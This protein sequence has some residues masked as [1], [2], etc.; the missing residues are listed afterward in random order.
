M[1][2]KVSITA[3]SSLDMEK[4]SEIYMGTSSFMDF[5][6][7][8]YF[9][10][11]TASY[12]FFT[13]TYSCRMQRLNA[14]MMVMVLFATPSTGGYV[15]IASNVGWFSASYIAIGNTIK[16]GTIT[17]Q[18]SFSVT[19]FNSNIPVLLLMKITDTEG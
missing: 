8:A 2:G 18:T 19:N 9:R 14:N 15:N 7:N 10:I 3:G 16:T 4:D 5:A 12:I 17:R 13:N 6:N 11:M 1:R